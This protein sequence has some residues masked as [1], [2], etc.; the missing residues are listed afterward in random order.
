MASLL[1]YF[2]WGAGA[3]TPAVD[4][5]SPTRALPVS[6][7]TSKEMFDLERRAIFSRR[8]LLITH[9]SRLTQPGDWLRYTISGF[10][11]VLCRDRDGNINGFHNVCRHRAYPVVEGN[12]GSA[13]IFACRYHGWSYGLNGKLAKAPGYQELDDFDKSKNSL[14][15]IHVHIDNNGF[16][17]INMDAKS[18]PELAWEDDFE[19][20]DKS[21]ELEHYNFNDYTFDH[22]WEMDGEFN[23]KVLADNYNESYY[24]HEAHQDLQTSTGDI[25]E[26][27]VTVDASVIQHKPSGL[28]TDKQEA[29][30]LDVTATYFFP[31]SSI[32]VS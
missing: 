17:W 24:S 12:A 7:Y 30:D 23:W 16:I 6:W 13:K 25:D 15:P 31:N 20:V 32:N 21:E 3:T 22:T 9:R 19:A 11:F 10:A 8:W 4:D 29:K 2:G 1:S 5:K 14:F 28:S 27:S 26:S 18:K